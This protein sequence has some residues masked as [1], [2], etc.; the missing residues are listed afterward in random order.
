MR[1]TYHKIPRWCLVGLITLCSSFAQTIGKTRATG[2]NKEP[3][4]PAQNA[5]IVDFNEIADAIAVSLEKQSR[6][7]QAR[8][9]Q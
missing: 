4:T 3:E 7:Q 1:S 5:R 6:I 9:L 8:Y 2:S